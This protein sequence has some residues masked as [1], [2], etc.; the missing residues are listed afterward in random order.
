MTMQMHP[1]L[2]LGLALGMAVVRGQASAAP[3]D[4][5]S[6]I[7]KAQETQ[8]SMPAYKV[9][10]RANDLPNGETVTSTLIFVS[11]DRYHSID[12]EGPATE[13]I[14]IGKS[15][16]IKIGHAAFE[17]ETFDSL[18]I[19]TRF[20]GPTLINDPRYELMDARA[21]GPAKIQG[22]ETLAY[23]YA[24][25]GRGETS[26]IRLWVARDTGLPV[27]AT[28]EFGNDVVKQ[29]I[30][31]DIE[32][33]ATL[34]VTPPSFS[35]EGAALDALWLLFDEC[36]TLASSELHA[37]PKAE[38]ELGMATL[39]RCVNAQPQDPIGFVVLARLL[40]DK[41]YRDPGLEDD[42]K[43]AH[44]EWGLRCTGRAL[45]LKKDLFEAILWRGLLLRV[46]AKVVSNEALQRQLDAEADAL[47]DQVKRLRSEGALPHPDLEPGQWPQPPS[48]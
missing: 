44:L 46:K 48:R 23:E 19:L 43:L 5:R 41:A 34:T 47:R 3:E 24:M 7:L 2:A 15:G 17:R 22:R 40:W 45:A 6:A 16:W 29:R 28:D 33:D 38:F 25:S 39:E 42:E 13:V 31:W 18:G 8:A 11:P 1:T 4:A 26:R 36:R 30:S 37:K 21:L 10:Y 27:R 14:R 12:H 20:R 9:E 35:A 32:Y